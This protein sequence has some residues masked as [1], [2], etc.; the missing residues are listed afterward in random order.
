MEE[1]GILYLWGFFC[2]RNIMMK[3]HFRSQNY[4]LAIMPVSDCL[5]RLWSLP[6]LLSLLVEW[7][8]RICG[9][10]PPMAG[11]TG[12]RDLRRK[13]ECWLENQ[14]CPQ[15]RCCWMF[16]GF[17]NASWSRESYSAPRTAAKRLSVFVHYS[18]QLSNA[19][20]GMNFVMNNKCCM[21]HRGHLYKC[22]LYKNIGLQKGKGK[23]YANF[24]Q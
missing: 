21:N 7:F 1:T 22:A 15:G 16:A 13:A 10:G 8:V 14:R 2:G 24:M 4:F 9:A 6:E 18:G 3:I 20:C 11:C 12:L 17:E 5:S 19:S 23:V